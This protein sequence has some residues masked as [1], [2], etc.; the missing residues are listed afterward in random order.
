M[1]TTYNEAKAMPVSCE[2]CRT[3]EICHTA[4]FVPPAA[5]RMRVT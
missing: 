5:V 3:R 1:A 4:K 2:I